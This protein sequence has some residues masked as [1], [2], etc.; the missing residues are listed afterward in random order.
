MK[1]KSSEKTTL[2]ALLIALAQVENSL[3]EGLR[4]EIQEIARDL[5]SNSSNAISKIS[6]LVEKDK[7]LSKLYQTA[8][9]NL[10][11]QYQA[12]ERDKFG[13]NIADTLSLK[14]AGFLENI[15]YQI[16][17]SNNFLATAQQI[18]QKLQNSQDSFIKTL[19]MAVSVA[20]AKADLKA[21][22]ISPSSSSALPEKT[23]QIGLPL[24]PIWLASMYPSASSVGLVSP[25]NS[26]F[27]FVASEANGSLASFSI[28]SMPSNRSCTVPLF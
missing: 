1:L 22:S 11:R 20:K 17:Y 24:G 28:E 12:Q 16:L 2:Q 9:L 10:L 21:I 6:T 13:I 15:A 14:D 5:E 19:Q 23:K 27:L 26:K 3:S 7:Q 8:R 25:S 18:V 4:Q